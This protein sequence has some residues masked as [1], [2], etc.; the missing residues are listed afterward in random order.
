MCLCVVGHVCL[1]AA[2]LVSFALFEAGY[3]FECVFCYIGG[4]FMVCHLVCLLVMWLL[5]LLLYMC[6][7]SLIPWLLFKVG[8]GLAR[9]GFHNS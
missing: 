5:L 9:A 1:S 7:L 4:G 6:V 2:L 8:R 3:L